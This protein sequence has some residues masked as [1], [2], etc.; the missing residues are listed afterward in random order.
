MTKFPPIFLKFHKLFIII[1]FLIFSCKE[2]I[3]APIAD[4]SYSIEKK[5]I[6]FKNLSINASY[7]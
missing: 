6:I 4:F 2:E 5:E 7:L 3:P 1:T